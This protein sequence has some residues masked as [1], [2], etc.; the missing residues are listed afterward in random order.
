MLIN[1]SSIWSA[2]VMI[3]EDAEDQTPFRSP[4]LVTAV[5]AVAMTALLVIFV[6]L[7]RQV[8]QGFMSGAVKG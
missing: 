1:S 2:V 4:I 5:V 3:F 8:T 6:V 7:Q